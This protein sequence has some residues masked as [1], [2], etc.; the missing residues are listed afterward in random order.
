MSYD[1]A[2]NG[3]CV[4]LAEGVVDGLN[5]GVRAGR[6]VTLT[7]DT[8]AAE[9]VVDA[10]GLTVMPGVI[11]EHFHV[12]RGYGW[13][14]HEGATRAA[15]KGGVTTVVDMPIDKPA[16]LSADLVGEKR[17]AI[18][19][20]CYVDYALFGGYPAENPDDMTAMVASGVMVFKL[21]TGELSPPGMYPGVTDAQVLDTMRRAKALD[22]TVVVHCENESIVEFETARLRDGGRQDLEVWNEARPWFSEVEASQRVALLAEVTGCRTVLA[23]VTHPRV[24][25]VV[26]AARAR[27]VDI[28]VETAPHN[29]LITKE[30]M[31]RDIRLKW[32][33]PSRSRADVDELWSML[34]H[35][36][37][38]TIGS[39]HAPLAK[40]E[41]ADIWTQAPGAGNSVETMFE[42][43][44]TE[45]LNGRNISLSRLADLFSTTPA[46]V[47]GLFPRKG[48][49][50]IGSDA[51]FVVAETAGRRRIDATELEYLDRSAA[52]S[53]FDGKEMSVYPV[54]TIVRGR[55][56]CEHGHVVGSPIYGQLITE[57]HAVA[58]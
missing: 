45:A 31:A 3:G 6:I 37:V 38:H 40:V 57:G 24:A 52:W 39:D 28:W 47:F 16:I 34:A 10:S 55:V 43:V 4:V 7:S 12:F 18:S 32:N 5:I 49:I 20:S 46:K 42:V 22:V 56:V 23:H 54:Y 33:P 53:P 11:D 8:L 44:A 13:E 9:R 1:L 48:T 2:L 36:D 41:G 19:Q 30:D 35:G 26:A 15:A 14:T 17:D 25:E 51:D 21:F 58:L 29:L 27:G 50:A